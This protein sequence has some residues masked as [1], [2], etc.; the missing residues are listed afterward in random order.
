L[1]ERN[2]R[3]Q[4]KISLKLPGIG[5]MKQEREENRRYKFNQNLEAAY[6]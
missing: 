6:H 1:F 2:A 3:Y 4:S 5:K